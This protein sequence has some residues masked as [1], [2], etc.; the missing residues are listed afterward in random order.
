[1][2]E[3][4]LACYALYGA[5]AFGLRIL[6][7]LRATGSSGVRGLSGRPGSVEWFAGLGLIL[8]IALA[9]IAAARQAE[10]EVEPLEALDATGVQTAGIVLFAL[11]LAATF[12]AQ[13]AMGRSW[14]IGVDESERTELVTHGPFRLVRNP[15]YS[16]MLPAFAGLALMAPN[17]LALAAP[18]LLFVSLELQV[19]VAEEP[20]LLR[21]HGDDYAEYA[22]R[23]GRF[24]PGVGRIKR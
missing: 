1:V 7:Q 4:A 3:L 23:V 16:A 22:A 20:H 18:V 2:P 14:R 13:L 9:V 24:V 8:G 10:G 15:I 5:V 19:R 17:P 21:T 11:G 12:Y 6:L